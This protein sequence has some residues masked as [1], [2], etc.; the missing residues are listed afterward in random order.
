[1]LPQTQRTHRGRHPDSNTSRRRTGGAYRSTSLFIANCAPTPFNQ[2]ELLVS[3]MRGLRKKNAD[4]AILPGDN[5]PMV[6]NRYL[7]CWELL[8][9][10]GYYI[11]LCVRYR[12][13]V[14]RFER[15]ELLVSTDD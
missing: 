8:E 1:M 2:P 6:S 15:A 11:D 7:S 13:C 10:L 3:A 5:L 12:E 14:L 9:R 4:L